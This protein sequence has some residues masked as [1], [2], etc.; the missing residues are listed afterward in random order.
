MT[1]KDILLFGVYLSVLISILSMECWV[2]VSQSQKEKSFSSPMTVYAQS[3]TEET[4]ASP[5]KIEHP[6]TISDTVLYN[7]D[8]VIPG[9]SYYAN[10]WVVDPEGKT[11]GETTTK[12]VAD[13]SGQLEVSIVIDEMYTNTNYVVYENIK[14]I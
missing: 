14:E 8:N 4:K 9:N 2:F 5:I 1:K 7:T 6:T 12:F 3:Y 10:V 11:I 13:E